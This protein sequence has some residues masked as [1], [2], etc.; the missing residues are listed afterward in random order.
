MDAR[1]RVCNQPGSFDTE[2]DEKPRFFFLHVMK[3]GG[4]TL[5]WQIYNHF[6]RGRVYPDPS[7]DQP[8]FRANT[9]VPYL[10][11]QAAARS[12]EICGYTGHF[13]FAAIDLIAQDL[14]SFTIVRDPVERTISYLKQA[15]RYLPQFRGASLEDVYEDPV[16]FVCFIQN[17]Q[18]KIFSMTAQDGVS[19]ILDHV[20]VDQARL[21]FAK[22]NLDRVDLVGV[23]ER[24]DEFHRRL[25]SLTGWELQPVPPQRVSERTDVPPSLRRR[26]ERDNAADLAFYEYARERF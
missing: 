17:H 15:R 22:S 1:P 24:Y 14:V 26:I 2:S 13:P 12:E 10:R 19:G 9:D 16:Q 25:R 18:S 11:E 6:P 7:H 3:T 23:H 21:T 8:L 20:E 5:R 4:S